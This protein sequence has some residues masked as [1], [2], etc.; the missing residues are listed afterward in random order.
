MELILRELLQY[1]IVVSC[2]TVLHKVW[3]FLL[4]RTTLLRS[5][6]VIKQLEIFVLSGERK[7]ELGSYISGTQNETGNC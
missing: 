3:P 2:R 6:F 5:D 4:K 7:G 1:I